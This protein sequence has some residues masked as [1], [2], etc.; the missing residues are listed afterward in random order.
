MSMLYYSSLS[1]LYAFLALGEPFS[2]LKASIFYLKESMPVLLEGSSILK[3]P[4][5]SLREPDSSFCEP[6]FSLKE[7]KSGFRERD[8]PL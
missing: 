6:M 1:P 8:S 3:K 5:F 7:S 4:M 2:S